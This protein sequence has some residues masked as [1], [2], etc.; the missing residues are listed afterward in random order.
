[1]NLPS[2]RSLGRNKSKLKVE[3]T[4]ILVADELPRFVRM[5]RILQARDPASDIKICFRIEATGNNP[6][7]LRVQQLVL[8]PFKALKFGQR[9]LTL[10]GLI[11]PTCARSLIE[12]V[13]PE[14]NWVRAWAWESYDLM[15]SIARAGDEAFRLGSFGCARSKYSACQDLFGALLQIDPH[16]FTFVDDGFYQSCLQVTTVCLRNFGLCGL[17][18]ECWDAVA[19]G[20]ENT[21]LGDPVHSTYTNSLG[22]HCFGVALA[23]KNMDKKALEVLKKAEM[24]DPENDLLRNH[25]SIT[26]ERLAA[27]TEAA[28][29]AA[30]TI[31]SA[32]S[33]RHLGKLAIVPPPIL[34]TSRYIAG[35][36]YVLRHFG[37]TGNLLEGIRETAPANVKEMKEIIRKMEKDKANTPSGE[38]DGLWLGARG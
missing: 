23:A 22:F 17:R 4:F 16:L 24:L 11:E 31:Y 5:L 7:P 33:L 35:E 6:P 26:L 12:S 19:K 32:A 37:Y 30:G 28:K 9:R 3:E 8:E 34:T 1:M 38:F 18:M 13:A 10:M 20:V 14:V 2:G 21:G 15:L 27:K 25:V 36:R 29:T